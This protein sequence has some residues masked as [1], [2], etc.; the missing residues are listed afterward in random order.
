M[1]AH[2]P[3]NIPNAKLGA[4]AVALHE[5][6]VLLVRVNYG[7]AKGCWVLPGG[8]V[9]H[10]EPIA[11]AAKREVLEETNVRI[12]PLGIVGI[13]QRMHPEIPTDIYFLFLAAVEGE[14]G[15][16]RSS[17]PEEITE[18]AFW[19]VEEAMASPEVRPMAKAAIGWALSKRNCFQELE[20]PPGF[21]EGD[22]LFA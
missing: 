21:A 22:I 16:L 19:K 2:Q 13:R 11:E 7:P 9:E 17:D 12:R 5:G 6:R 3:W 8:R 15:E 1:S 10:N 14:P 4:G 18:V 20:R